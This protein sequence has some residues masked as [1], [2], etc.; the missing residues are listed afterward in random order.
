MKALSLFPLKALPCAGLAAVLL[1]AA[2]VLAPARAA[3]DFAV[4]FF[5]QIVW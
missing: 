2:A 5:Q 3:F 4:E 1:L